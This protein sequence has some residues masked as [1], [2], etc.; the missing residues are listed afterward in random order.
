MVKKIEG[1]DKLMRI[2]TS[3]RNHGQGIEYLDC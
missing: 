1:E 3:R 2:S